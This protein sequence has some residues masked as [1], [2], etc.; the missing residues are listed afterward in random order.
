MTVWTFNSTSFKSL[1]TG[2]AKIEWD[3]TFYFKPPQDQPDLKPQAVSWI[4]PVAGTITMEDG[5]TQL[6]VSWD[7]DNRIFKLESTAGSTTVDSYIVKSEIRQLVAAIGGD[8]YATGNSN[9]ST[10]TNVK[11]RDTV[12]DLSSASVTANNIPDN[13]TVSKAF[14][15]WSGWKNEES[16]NYFTDAGTTFGNWNAGASWSFSSPA[17]NFKGTNDALGPALE[18]KN[19]QDLHTYAGAIVSWKQWVTAGSTSSSQ[20]NTAASDT[21]NPTLQEHGLLPERIGPVN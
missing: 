14:L 11:F 2:T 21:V 19:F 20:Q 5:T 16:I 18:L 4:V 13:A 9:L 7:A 17:G 10:S 8:Y 6:P 3:A 12:H 1:G 15:Y